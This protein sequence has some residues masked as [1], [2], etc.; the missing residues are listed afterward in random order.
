MDIAGTQRKYIAHFIDRTEILTEAEGRDYLTYLVSNPDAPFRERRVSQLER[1][2]RNI[3]RQKEAERLREDAWMS[4][5]RE[6]VAV[7][8][9]WEALG[10][11]W[12]EKYDC[13]VGVTTW[14]YNGETLVRKW[15]WSSL[16]EELQLVR[17]GDAKLNELLQ[18][19]VA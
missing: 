10:A 15:T 17:E 4:K 8:E 1:Y 16:D 11:T 9:R 14:T 2:L 5:A 12:D 18:G 7:K 13:G 19:D 6:I 3:E